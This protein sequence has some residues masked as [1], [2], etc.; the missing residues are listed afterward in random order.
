M[1]SEFRDIPERHETGRHEV[2]FV[3]TL[4]LAGSDQFDEFCVRKGADDFSL[5]GSHVRGTR[6]KGRG[7]TAAGWLGD[8]DVN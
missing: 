1:S 6:R 7:R 8:A 5:S 2:D 3:L 4:Q